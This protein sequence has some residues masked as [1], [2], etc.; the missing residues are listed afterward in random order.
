MQNKSTLLTIAILV[1]M[2]VVLV[3]VRVSPKDSPQPEVQQLVQNEPV[4]S[5]QYSFGPLTTTYVSGQTWPPVVTMTP[6]PYSCTAG[7]TQNDDTVERVIGTRTYCVT[8]HTEGATG[9]TYREYTYRTGAT[10]ITFTLRFSGCSAYD[11][12]QKAACET[13]QSGFSAD[14]LVADALQQ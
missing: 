14:Q 8:T 6:G 11:N 10:Q 3:I 5:L 4:Q 13:E 9:S 1:A 12:L 2:V 7:Q